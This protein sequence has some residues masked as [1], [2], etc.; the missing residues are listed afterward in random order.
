MLEIQIYH[1]VTN[2]TVAIF[3]NLYF[4]SLKQSLLNS[5]FPKL[6]HSMFFVFEVNRN[7]VT[8]QDFLVQQALKLEFEPRP[9]R[10][11]ILHQLM[12]ILSADIVI[13]LYDLCV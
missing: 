2:T 12:I 1:Q 6:Y 5:K 11:L 7:I 8:K 10:D 3:E 13:L 4:S 9:N